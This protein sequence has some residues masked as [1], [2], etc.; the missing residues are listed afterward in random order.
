M[1]A[2]SSSF[3]PHTPAQWLELSRHMV[4]PVAGGQ[5]DQG[6]VT[7]HYDPAIAVPFASATQESVLQ[8]EAALWQ[9]Y[10]GIT[11]QT[12]LLRGAQSDLLSPSTA[13]QMTQRGPK[14]RLVEFAG[15]GHAPTLIAPDQIEVV[16]SFLL[17]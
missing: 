1:W 10:D 17:E 13:L 15:V 6:P 4:K 5:I 7:L 3:G 16:A 14:A 9:L 12:L 11:A 8:G 2:I